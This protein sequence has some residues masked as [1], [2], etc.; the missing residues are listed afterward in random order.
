MRKSRDLLRALK[1]RLNREGALSGT[2]VLTGSTRQDAVCATAE[3]LTGRIHTLT[4]H[5]L[6]Q[7]EIAGVHEDLLSVLMDDP[8]EAVA[9]YPTS[10]TMRD[11]YITRVCAGGFPLALRRSGAARARWF[12]DYVLL[13][14][15]CSFRGSSLAFSGQKRVRGDS[16]H[17]DL[18]T[19][20]RLLDSGRDGIDRL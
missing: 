11:D 20:L 18:G 2:A 8:D 15:F 4:I 12:D 7:G 17:D 6:S 3:A 13:W 14:V 9:A 10:T 16:M 1:A 19:A 5:P